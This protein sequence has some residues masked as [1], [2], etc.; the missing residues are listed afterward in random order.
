MTVIPQVTLSPLIL[1]SPTMEGQELGIDTNGVDLVYQAS[2]T[3]QA[4][5]VSIEGNSFVSLTPT[6]TAGYNQFTVSITG[7]TPSS[8]VIQVL[9]VGT[10]YNPANPPVTGPY[11]ATPTSSFG[12]VYTGLSGTLPVLNLS[13]TLHPESAPITD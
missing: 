2:T 5:T 10:S 9:A 1:I 11:Y 7:I 3:V 13:L 4:V 6:L 8:S 12:L